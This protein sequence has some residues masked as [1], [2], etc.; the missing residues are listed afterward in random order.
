LLQNSNLENST[1]LNLNSETNS[2][3]PK[4]TL[5][6]VPSDDEDRIMCLKGK[7]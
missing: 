1:N 7:R 2:K 6:E 3:L 5:V 4:H